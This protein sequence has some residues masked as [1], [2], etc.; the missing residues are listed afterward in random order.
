MNI[1]IGYRVK[2][3]KK[4][5]SF[6]IILGIIVIALVSSY[7]STTDWLKPKLQGKTL[8]IAHRAGSGLWPQN[9]RTA[10]LNSV[11]TSK[12]RHSDSRYLG[13]E[14]DVVLTGENQVVLSHDPWIHKLLCQKTSGE[15]LNEQILIKNLTLRELQSGFLCGGLP[16]P[17]FPDVIP[18]AE[19]IPTLNEVLGAL[20]T[21][22]GM[23]L[24]LDVK[25]DG[26]LTASPDAYAEALAECLDKA[27]LPNKIYIEGPDS[28]S[29]AAF[30]ARIHSPFVASLSYPPFSTDENPVMTV[31]KSR[32][33]TKSR[34]KSPLEMARTAKAEAI[35]SHTAVITW[36]AAKQANDAGIEVI[37]FTPNTKKDLERY[38]HWPANILITDFP[39][40]GHCR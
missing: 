28:E 33:L 1:D 17:D 2:F 18:K 39:N 8:V 26:V 35:V 36:N 32:W 6:R 22:P 31:V 23:V 21:A 30:R 7:I 40:L 24:F 12:A 14:I 37:L 13:I 25:I 15:T 5:N 9:S 27:D 19:T 34:L 11:A 3:I 29:L 16:D 20:K 38:C 10:V 4:R